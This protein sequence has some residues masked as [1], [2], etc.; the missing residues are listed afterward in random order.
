MEGQWGK[1]L[2]PLGLLCLPCLTMYPTFNP[3]SW[4]QMR[5]PRSGDVKGLGPGHRA[6]LGAPFPSWKPNPVPPLL[7]QILEPEKQQGKLSCFCS[8][9]LTNIPTR[10]DFCS[11]S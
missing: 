4:W 9:N 1:A 2:P 6:A 11:D 7:V 5:K 8:P 10:G 3:A